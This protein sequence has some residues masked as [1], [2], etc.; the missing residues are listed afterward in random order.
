MKAKSGATNRM[1]AR[2]HSV[3]SRLRSIATGLFERVVTLTLPKDRDRR[4]PWVFS[5]QNGRWRL[6]RNGSVFQ[7]RGGSGWNY[8]QLDDLV[9]IGG[10]TVRGEAQ[11]RGLNRSRELGLSVVVNLPVYGEQDGINF[12]DGRDLAKQRH[13]VLAVVRRFKNHPAVLMWAVGNE[14]DVVIDKV[15][16]KMKPRHPALWRHLNDL[17]KDI[18][19]VDPIH[20][21]CVCVGL[22]DFKV[23]ISEMASVCQDVDLLGVNCFRNFQDTAH[24]L[25]ETWRRPYFYS[26][27]GGIPH[28]NVPR[29]DWGAVVEPTTGKK[30]QEIS[31]RYENFIRRDPNSVGSLLH[32]WGERSECT[33]TYWGLFYRGMRTE[34]LDEI[35]RHWTGSYPGNRC[36]KVIGLSI[37]GFDNPL[38]ITLS[39]HKEYRAHVLCFDPDGDILN[40]SWHIRKEVAR[41]AGSYAGRHEEHFDAI[42]GLILDEEGKYVR[43]FAPAEPGAYRLYVHVLDGNHN[44]G[45]GNL[46][47]LVSEPAESATEIER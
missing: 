31:D 47:I 43:F 20:P 46:P 3:P 39:P 8:E 5:R 2:L 44:A 10:N 26:E 37:E 15:N 32:F 36:P 25:A 12:D 30:A 6:T 7:I 29:T 11:R 17:A 1:S 23:K 24:V 21:V 33:H 38:N 41:P 13:C 34:V 4:H 45:H 19:T 14:L 28:W 42:S 40:I 18:K 9:D 16:D 22:S 27:W 35:Q